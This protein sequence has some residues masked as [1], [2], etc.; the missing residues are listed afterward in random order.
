MLLRGMW[1]S[2]IGDMHRLVAVVAIKR[3]RGLKGMGIGIL[4]AQIL[5]KD[6][7]VVEGGEV[8]FALG[9]EGMMS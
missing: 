2:I 6:I 8:D 9:C 4:H 5:V 7:V 3:I 1:I